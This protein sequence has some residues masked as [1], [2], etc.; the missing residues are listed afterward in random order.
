MPRVRKSSLLCRLGDDSNNRFPLAWAPSL[1]LREWRSPNDIF[2][3]AAMTPC[4]LGGTPTY[5]VEFGRYVET[6]LPLDRVFL[7]FHGTT[8]VNGKV[9]EEPFILGLQDLVQSLEKQHYCNNC[10]ICR[11]LNFCFQA[12]GW[13]DNAGLNQYRNVVGN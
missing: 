5:M 2:I 11:Y 4:H 1:F 10:N 3:I 6:F 9:A 13:R 8:T 12:L 7:A